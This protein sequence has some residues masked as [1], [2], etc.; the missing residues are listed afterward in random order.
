MDTLLIEFPRLADMLNNDVSDKQV[1]EKIWCMYH[2]HTVILN[3]D[4]TLLRILLHLCDTLKIENT[5]EFDFVKLRKNL[6]KNIEIQERPRW[7]QCEPKTAPPG[8]NCSRQI[9]L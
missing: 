8:L 3:Q 4:A 2:E 6:K 5:D 1:L 9:E 7:L